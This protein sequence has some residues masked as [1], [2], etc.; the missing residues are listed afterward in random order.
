MD[1]S[2][3]PLVQ[4]VLRHEWIIVT[5][6][7]RPRQP[8]PVLNSSKYKYTVD[9]CLPSYLHNVKSRSSGNPE[10]PWNQVV[11]APYPSSQSY[12]VLIHQQLAM[13]NSCLSTTAIQPQ[14][15]Q[16]MEG[17]I[18]A[19]DEGT[20]VNSGTLVDSTSATVLTVREQRRQ[21][22]HRIGAAGRRLADAVK[23]VKGHKA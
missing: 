9:T 8:S 6:S 22:V 4:E 18:S 7:T 16:S 12:A 15:A 1:I 5:P 19:T 21:I 13:S 11:S 10:S 2:L 20:A 23:G 3:R 17:V 14:V